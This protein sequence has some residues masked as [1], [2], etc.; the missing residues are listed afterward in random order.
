MNLDSADQLREEDVV[1][2]TPRLLR[3]VA[4]TNPGCRAVLMNNELLTHGT[5]ARTEL[6]TNA[7]LLNNE[8]F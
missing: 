2:A 4:C 7:T 5:F 6:L 3:L 1:R 8:G